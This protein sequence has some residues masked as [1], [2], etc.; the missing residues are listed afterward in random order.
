MDDMQ[1]TPDNR[2]FGALL[3][4]LAALRDADGARITAGHL[5]LGPGLWLSC[6]PQGQTEM[7]CQPA[8]AGFR[9]RI[10][11][12]DSGK[13]TCL[14]LHLPVDILRRGRYLGLLVEADTPGMVSFT[15]R[16]RYFLEG[17]DQQDAGPPMPVLLPGGR[18]EQLCHIPVDPALLGRATGCELNLFFHNDTLQGEFF[19]LEPL[20]IS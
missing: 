19:R 8:G 12:G 11:G 20:L 16:L 13:W 5:D 2:A 14:G 10:D 1:T 15:P 3:D 9:L 6:D 18:R 17:G 7:E 4:A